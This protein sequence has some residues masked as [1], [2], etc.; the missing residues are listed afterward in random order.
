MKKKEK[1]EKET[2][3][4]AAGF[5]PP[6]P[7]LWPTRLRPSE[8]TIIGPIAWP[9]CWEARESDLSEVRPKLNMITASMATTVE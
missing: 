4:A 9:L 6:P 8:G 1:L 2:T 3:M 7:Y 5:L